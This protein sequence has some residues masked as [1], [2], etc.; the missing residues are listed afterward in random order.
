MFIMEIYVIVKRC[1]LTGLELRDSPIYWKS[2]KTYTVER[3]T[4][5]V[6]K[7]DVNETLK[8]HNKLK[9]LFISLTSCLSNL[10]SES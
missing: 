6:H 8:V 10:V 7:Q 3:F 1:E 5:E 9:V 2:S 4:T